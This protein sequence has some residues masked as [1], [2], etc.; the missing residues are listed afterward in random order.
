MKEIGL[1]LEALQLEQSTGGI[2][3]GLNLHRIHNNPF[4]RHDQS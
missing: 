4:V 1:A 2:Q 3:D